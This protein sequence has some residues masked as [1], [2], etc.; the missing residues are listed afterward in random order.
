MPIG[1]WGDRLKKFVN[2]IK[3]SRKRRRRKT[4][5][6]KPKDKNT[7]RGTGNK[8]TNKQR[9]KERKKGNKIIT[10]N[11]PP[12]TAS[13]PVY[14]FVGNSHYWSDDELGEKGNKIKP[15][16]TSNKCPPKQKKKTTWIV[17]N[18]RR[19]INEFNNKAKKPGETANFNKVV[20]VMTTSNL[21]D[22]VIDGFW[23]VQW[24]FK[25][26]PGKYGHYFLSYSEEYPDDIKVKNKN[27]YLDS[28]GGYKKRRKTRKKRRRK[29]KGGGDEWISWLWPKN[30]SRKNK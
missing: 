4:Q 20:G 24:R 10:P 17:E 22:E 7:G 8:Q 15:K 13:R 12:A 9:K 25:R 16:K 27:L 11:T 18:S 1:L 30:K 14:D 5:K 29:R 23:V 21:S 6:R 26:T 2:R 3:K 19:Q 28:E